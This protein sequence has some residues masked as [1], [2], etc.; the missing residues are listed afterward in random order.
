MRAPP[1]Q[2][3]QGE[4]CPRR[5]ILSI[6]LRISCLA[7]ISSVPARVRAADPMPEEEEKA[8]AEE[9]APL[10]AKMVAAEEEAPLAAK[11]V[12]EAGEKNIAY[13]NFLELLNDGEIQRVQFYGETGNKVVATTNGE[14]VTVIGVPQESSNSPMSPL[15]TVAKVRDA[16]VPFTFESFNLAEYRKE[17]KLGD[18]IAQVGESISPPSIP[19]IGLPSFGN[20]FGGN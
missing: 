3:S 18:I 14:R 19:S 4:N 20:P 12:A 17:R 7:G 15:R 10:A 8:A 11:K 13:D 6:P 1:F 16:G 9:E 2:T 5:A